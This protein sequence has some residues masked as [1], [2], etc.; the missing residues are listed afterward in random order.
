MGC[1]IFAELPTPLVRFCPILLDPPT[2][3]KI[4]HHLC[5]FPNMVYSAKF[6]S[7]NFNCQANGKNYRANRKT[8]KLPGIC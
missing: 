2:P 3:P 6:H 4:G 5:M 8:E 1:P 7:L